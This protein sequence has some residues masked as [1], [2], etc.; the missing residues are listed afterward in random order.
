MASQSYTRETRIKP[1]NFLLLAALLGLPRPLLCAQK[2]VAPDPE[3][4]QEAVAN[5]IT[6]PAETTIPLVLKSSIN[7]KTAYVGEAIYCQTIYPITVGDRIAIPVGSYVK[8]TITQVV[9]PGRIKGKAKLGLRFDSLT[10]PSGMTRPLRATL[11]AFAGNGKEGFKR[12][13][14]K[15]EG[16]SGKGADAGRIARTTI[17]GAEIGTL[18]GI[19]SRSTVKG[20]GIGS[21]AGA[22]AGAIWVLAGR[23]KEILL[24]PGTSLEL[25]LVAPLVLSEDGRNN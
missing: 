11:S 10:L 14:N 18:A 7:S 5:G 12:D 2:P 4:P 1:M 21:A 22:A 16:E 23:G 19:G 24:R 20:L 13:E 17:T 8:G 9:R 25:E 6:I 15:I 3:P